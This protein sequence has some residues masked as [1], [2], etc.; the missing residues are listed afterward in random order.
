MFSESARRKRPETSGSA[1]RLESTARRMSHRQ[2]PRSIADA[3]E[4]AARRC[5]RF[6]IPRGI[7][8]DLSDGG[9]LADFDSRYSAF[10]KAV[11]VPMETLEHTPALALLGEPGMGK[12]TGLNQEAQRLADSARAKD[13]QV[14]LVDLAACG[15]D[16]TVRQMVFQSA[17]VREWKS[18][19]SRLHLLLDGF[20]TC[21]A[22]PV[23]PLVAVLL[24]G[25]REQPLEQ[26]LSLRISCRTAG[27]AA[28]PRIWAGTS[29][30]R[31]RHRRRPD[32][33]F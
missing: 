13:D 27:M 29:L 25:L 20:D 5:R 18:G 26:R 22:H 4:V 10:A 31:R 1:C 17:Q 32:R 2:D 33:S 23:R 14:R 15:S 9:F 16:V 6:W 28:G 30:E 3:L 11:A 12:S 21:L 8:P 24:D 7:V 19:C